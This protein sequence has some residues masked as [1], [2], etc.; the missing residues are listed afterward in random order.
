[1]LIRGKGLSNLLGVVA[2]VAE[3][4]PFLGAIIA[5]T[6]IAL[7]G[8]SSSLGL[9]V[10]GA[11][12]YLVINA[13]IA[14]LVTPRVMGQHLTMHPFVV[15]VS[16]LAGASLLGPAGALLALPGAA[17]LQALVESFATRRREEAPA[18]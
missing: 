10:I 18:P 11:V 8:Y 6:A 7:T 13:L 4:V 12:A 17:T 16:I 5:T 15:T 9:A 14:A 2:G 3:V 1:M